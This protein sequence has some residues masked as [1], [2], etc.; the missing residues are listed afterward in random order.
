MQRLEF[1]YSSSVKTYLKNKFSYLNHYQIPFLKKIVIN[2]GFDD[3]CQTSK[4]LDTLLEE[5]NLITCQF[6]NLTVSSFSIASFKVREGMPVGMRVT[7]RGPKMYAFLDRLIN[8]TLPRIRDFQ[9]L[10][11]KSFDGCGNYNL[12]LKEQLMFPEIELDKV[13]KVKGFNISII[14]STSNNFEAFELLKEMGMPF[15]V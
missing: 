11:P 4:V 2:R 13:V 3:S 15:R 6:P 1:Y 14:T 12:G 5:L 8:L 9:G 7:L 10:N